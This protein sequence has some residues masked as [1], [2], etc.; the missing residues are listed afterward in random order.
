MLS[1]FVIAFLPIPRCFDC[2]TLYFNLKLG[3]VMPPDLSLFLRIALAIHSLCCSIQVLG[4]FVL[5]LWKNVIGILIE[6]ALN[7]HIML[8]NMEIFAKLILSIHEHRK[9]FYFGVFFHFFQEYLNSFECTISHIL[10]F[11][12]RYF[13]LFAATINGTIFYI[14]DSSKK[15]KKTFLYWFFTLKL[16]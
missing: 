12:H 4:F 9:H 1:R 2:Y 16:C 15:W 11:T 7:T 10:K 13:I 14:S 8:S 3:S 5:F 6:I